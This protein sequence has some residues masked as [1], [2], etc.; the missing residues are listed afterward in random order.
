MPAGEVA[1]DALKGPT[2]NYRAPMLLAKR[3]LI[4]GFNAEALDELLAD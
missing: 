4:V 3:K 1:L 2:G